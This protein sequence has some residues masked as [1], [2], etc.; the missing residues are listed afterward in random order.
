MVSNAVQLRLLV[1]YKL[2]SRRGLVSRADLVA[3]LDSNDYFL[4]ASSRQDAVKRAIDIGLLHRDSINFLLCLNRDYDLEQ[5]I[6]PL[7]SIEHQQ[8]ALIDYLEA[9]GQCH[10]KDLKLAVFKME[11]FAHLKRPAVTY[12]MRVFEML[13]QF[14]LDTVCKNSRTDFC[15]KIRDASKVR[16]VAALPDV[17]VPPVVDSNFLVSDK[18]V[19]IARMF[20]PYSPGPQTQTQSRVAI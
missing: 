10:I 4:T 3:S 15:L 14:I 17:K 9:N 16:R 18:S 7:S 6:I 13:E 20:A 5:L 2:M 1:I 11:A 12:R 19:W 8:I